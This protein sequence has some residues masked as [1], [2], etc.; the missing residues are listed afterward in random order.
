MSNFIGPPTPTTGFPAPTAVGPYRVKPAL[1]Q[2]TTPTFGSMAVLQSLIGQT[3]GTNGVTGSNT[4]INYDPKAGQITIY[5]PHLPESIKLDRSVSYAQLGNIMTMP[6]GMPFYEYTNPLEI[7]IEFSIH[8]WDPLCPEGPNSLL[9]IAACLHAL[10]LPASND[11]T[12]TLARAPIKSR[13]EKSDTSYEALLNAAKPSG[14]S[15]SLQDQSQALVTQLNSNVKW[16]PAC[17][18]SLMQGG[19]GGLGIYCVGYIKEV[20]V[21]LKGPWLSGASQSQIFNMPSLATCRFV[22]VH[23]P[24]YTNN[25][26]IGNI[27]SA[28]GPDVLNNFYDLYQLASKANNS[29]GGIDTLDQSRTV[30]F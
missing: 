2:G 19:P 5:I 1:T 29:Y 20:G 23:N 11:D 4:G 30:V 26:S 16:P 6:D 13:D 8:A 17:T 27:V 21:E 7:P 25:T 22:F 9:V 15:S 18:L 24:S 10:A 14:N 3:V 28:F 12:N